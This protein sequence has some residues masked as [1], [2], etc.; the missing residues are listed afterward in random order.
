MS[1]TETNYIWRA[2]NIS[3][4][5]W[6]DTE[7]VGNQWTNQDYPNC[8]IVGSA[9][10]ECWEDRLSLRLQWKTISWRWYEKLATTAIIIIIIIMIIII[11]IIIIIIIIIIISNSLMSACFFN[12]VTFYMISFLKIVI[13][14]FYTVSLFFLLYAIY[15]I[16][17]P[18]KT[19]FMLLNL[20]SVH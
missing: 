11:V 12:L 16:L 6:K 20:L 2:W 13:S 1:D 19:F 5:L 9:W 3:K 10:K 18:L 17:F 8:T 4:R 7:I 14:V 15:P